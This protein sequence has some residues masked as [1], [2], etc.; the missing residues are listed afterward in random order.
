MLQS[1]RFLNLFTN[2]KSRPLLYCAFLLILVVSATAQKIPG[3]L[4]D[5][6]RDFVQTPAVPGYE[7]EL[8]AKISKRLESLKP[9]TDEMSNVI[10]TVGSGSPRRLIVTPMDEPGYVVSGITN[11]GYLRLQRLPQGGSL[12]L[13]NEL[14]SAQPVKIGTGAQQWISGAVAG[15]SIHLQ[16]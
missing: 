12:P 14:H 7:Q 3:T 11:D 15:L 8:A 6:L 9:K 13:F 5:D 16:P 2:Y 10:V 1:D 4:S